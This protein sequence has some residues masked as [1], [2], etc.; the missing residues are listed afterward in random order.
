MASTWYVWKCSNHGVVRHVKKEY[1]CKRLDCKLD[2]VGYLN[3]NHETDTWH[4]F[5]DLPDSDVDLVKLI[6]PRSR[7]EY[8]SIL[9]SKS[10]HE[11][12]GIQTMLLHNVECNVIGP[13]FHSE[14][15]SAV[16]ESIKNV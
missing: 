15:V 2:C 13:I 4:N 12:G 8:R 3:F 9:E 1:K 14:I 7:A 5:T 10:D 6:E 16:N 11:L